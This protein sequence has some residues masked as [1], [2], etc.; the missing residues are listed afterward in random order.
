MTRMHAALALFAVAT[1]VFGYLLWA[2]GVAW[3]G[4][5]A[6]SAMLTIYA[7]GELYGRKGR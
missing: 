4:P 1:G 6:V 3:C 2:R 5:Y 7:L